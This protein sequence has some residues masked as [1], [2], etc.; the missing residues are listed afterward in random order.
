MTVLTF[1]GS[2]EVPEMTYACTG[3]DEATLWR[4]KDQFV[5]PDISKHLHSQDRTLDICMEDI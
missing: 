3:Q 5:P 2:K 1:S 4:P